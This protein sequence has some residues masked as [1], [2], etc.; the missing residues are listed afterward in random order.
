MPVLEVPD[1]PR[2]KAISGAS[3][4]QCGHGFLKLFDSKVEGISKIWKEI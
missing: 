4:H 1:E 2:W 3:S